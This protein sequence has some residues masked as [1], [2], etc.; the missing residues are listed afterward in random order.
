MSDKGAGAETVKSERKYSGK[1]ISLDLDTV[2]FPDGTLG[3]LEMIRHPGASAVV[4]FLDDPDAPDPTILLIRQYRYAANQF[5]LE[6]PA[7]RLEPDE[8][9]EDCASRELREETG[10]TPRRL[11]KV[12]D[13]FTTPGFTD[14]RIHIFFAWDLEKGEPAREQDEFITE[15]TLKLSEAARLVIT[16]SI[17]DAKTALGILLASRFA[18]AR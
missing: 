10:R 4:P 3:D 6:I 12:F 16:G 7:G 2:R 18:Q 5:L 1:V 14:E 8:S 15:V 13:L 11:R 17:T 9:P